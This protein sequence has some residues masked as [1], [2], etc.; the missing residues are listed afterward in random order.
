MGGFEVEGGG[1]RIEVVLEWLGGILRV[2][3][4][5]VALGGR[6][7]EDVLDGDDG[8]V[9]VGSEA[10]DAGVVGGYSVS[11]RGT[12]VT[13]DRNRLAL[14]SSR[15]GNRSDSVETDGLIQRGTGLDRDARAEAEG[16]HAEGVL[17]IT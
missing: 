6:G 4:V 14:A 1:L 3:G 13:P 8:G 5:G 11:A 17:V 9:R 2:G 7:A 10:D 15:D 12:E 16:L